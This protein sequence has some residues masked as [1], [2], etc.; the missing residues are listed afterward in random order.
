MCHVA[1][2]FTQLVPQQHLLR[3][4]RA[5]GSAADGEGHVAGAQGAGLVEDL[6]KGRSGV[7]ENIDIYIDI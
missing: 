6:Q 4:H 5:R 1:A 7:C 2:G 3:Q